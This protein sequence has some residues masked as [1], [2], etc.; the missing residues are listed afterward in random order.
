MLHI[1]FVAPGQHTMGTITQRLKA[2]GT[3]SYTAQIRIKRQG[4]VVYQQSQTFSKKAVAQAWIKKR[5]TEL[6]EPGALDAALNKTDVTVAQAIDRYIEENELVRDMGRTKRASLQAIARTW[7][8]ELQAHDV[9]SQVLVE[10]AQ[11]RMKEDGIQSSTVGNDLAHLGSVFS[12]AQ[13]AWG[14]PLDPAEMR[15][16]RAVLKSMGIVGP[17]KERDRRPTLEELD[18]ILS[19]YQDQKARRQQEIDMLRVVTFAL[20][21][22]RRQEEITRISLDKTDVENRRFLITDMKSP[23]QKWGNDVWCRMP[24]EAW[25]IMMSVPKSV[26]RIPFPYNSK[27]ISAS[28]TRACQFLAIEDLHFHDLRHEGI[29]RLF[30]IGWDIPQVASVSGHRN[31]NSMRRYTHLKGEGDKYKDW[32]WLE[33]VIHS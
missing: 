9:T 21:S 25:Q 18:L 29:S 23:G 14:Y 16:A 11:R 6:A 22:T 13:P 7:I 31:W 19:H 27:S 3:P 15:S 2:D 4:K 33:R 24:E 32:P 20:F 28:F 17:S 10:Y 26:G 8:G 5:E 12:V 30:E 1:S